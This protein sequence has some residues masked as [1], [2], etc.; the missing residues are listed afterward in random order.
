MAHCRSSGGHG[1]ALAMAVPG[2]GRKFWTMTSCTWP[3]RACEAAMARSAASW[4][5]RSSPMPTR[6]PVVKGMASSPAAS[7]V[8]S[9]RA[10]SL[11]GAPRCASRS[12][13]SDSSIIPWLADTGRSVASSSA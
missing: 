13:A 7:S 9:R 5:A 10:G 12:S 2:L 4:P 6:I 3:W 11:S 8:A 1:A